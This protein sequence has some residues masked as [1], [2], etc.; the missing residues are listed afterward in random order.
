MTVTVAR[1]QP[2]FTYRTSGSRSGVFLAEDAVLAAGEW[3]VFTDATLNRW[4]IF[5]DALHQ[6]AFVNPDTWESFDGPAEVAFEADFIEAYT[7]SRVRE[8][9]FISFESGPYADAARRQASEHGTDTVRAKSRMAEV[10]QLADSLVLQAAGL[11]AA[12]SELQ[13]Q[14][15]AVRHSQAVADLAQ[16]E[17]DLALLRSKVSLAGLALVDVVS[18]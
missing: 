6:R 4:E 12:P 11:N 3:M 2:A 7:E 14:I 8:M 18:R 10:A 17:A 1:R 9:R 13:L 5:V 15:F 16:L